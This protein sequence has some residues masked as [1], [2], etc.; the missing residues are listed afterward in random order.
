MRSRR[1]PVGLLPRDFTCG[2]GE[3]RD[4]DPGRLYYVLRASYYGEALYPD[5]TMHRTLRVQRHP[6][7]ST[8]LVAGTTTA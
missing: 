6:R 1:A 3:F 8:I 7:S 2:K 4:D 5:A